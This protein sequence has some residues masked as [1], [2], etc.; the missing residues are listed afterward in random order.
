[1]HQDFHFADLLLPPR[2]AS[3]VNAVPVQHIRRTYVQQ[4]RCLCRKIQRCLCART[5]PVQ[6]KSVPV[7]HMQC[8]CSRNATHVQQSQSRNARKFR[9]PVGAARICWYRC[10]VNAVPLQQMRRLCS[11]CGA[12]AAECSARAANAVPVQH[13]C[14]ASENLQFKFHV[15]FTYDK[16]QGA[17]KKCCFVAE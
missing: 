4:M 16:T 5:A 11:K 12:C 6:Q 10:A 2:S 7:Q 13:K 1:M 9:V 3:T 17:L 15:S 14:G 8:L